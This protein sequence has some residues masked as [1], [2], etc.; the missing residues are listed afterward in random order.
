V[1]RCVRHKERNVLEHLPERDRPPVKARLRKP[2]A[3]E[4]YEHLLA[5]RTAA[6]TTTT[7][8]IT[9]LATIS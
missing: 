1:H 8:Q 5:Q 6:H 2:W 7:P 3:S 4:N 9:T